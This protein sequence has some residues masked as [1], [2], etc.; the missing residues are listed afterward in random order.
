MGRETEP[1]NRQQYYRIQ[2]QREMILQRM[3]ETGC[4]I[5]KQRMLILDV[6]LSENCTSCKE[7][8]YLALKEDHSIGAATV[9]R[10]VNLLEE[11]GAISP[12]KRYE[13]TCIPGMQENVICAE[14]DDNSVVRL[15]GKNLNSVIQEGLKACGDLGQRS[16]VSVS[17][18]NEDT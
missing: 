4:R 1:D 18:E 11:I 12:G 7:I 16:V 9:Y 6:I 13:I 8:Y 2:M 15:S 14:L 10:M 5:T 17:V 3:K